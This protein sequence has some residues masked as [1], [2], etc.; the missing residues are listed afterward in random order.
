M[1]KIRRDGKILYNGEQIGRHQRL[2]IGGYEVV[3]NGVQGKLGALYYADIRTVVKANL[4]KI[5]VNHFQ[6]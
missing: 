6:T 3:L 2:T 5:K 1:I 4:D